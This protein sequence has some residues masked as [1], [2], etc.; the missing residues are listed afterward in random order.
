[1]PAKMP[2]PSR[3]FTSNKTEE[4]PQDYCD[5]RAPGYDNNVNSN[6]KERWLTGA[7]QATEKPHYDKS[8]KWF[9]TK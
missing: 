6:P 7:V 9:D 4:A 3:G 5:K 8:K 1:M 2:T